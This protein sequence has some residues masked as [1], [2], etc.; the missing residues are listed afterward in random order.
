M[1]RILMLSLMMGLVAS[2]TVAGLA[3]EKKATLPT[4]KKVM[5][6]IKKGLLKKILEETATPKEQQQLL[7]YV[8]ALP[9][10]PPPKG[11]ADSWKQKT[12]E[13][14]KGTQAVVKG[15]P[16]AIERLKQASNCKAC[17]SVHKVYP[18]K[19][20]KPKPKK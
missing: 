18:P 7:E 20:K 12:A 5:Q 13:L 8:K 17:H 14:I 11:E 3:A 2:L 1:K 19:P 15:Q 9:G 4:T 10:N 6:A 16:K